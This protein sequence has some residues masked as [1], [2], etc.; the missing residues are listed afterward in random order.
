VSIVT[1]Q[2]AV[3]PSCHPSRRRMDSSALNSHLLRGFLGTRESVL[4]TA[5]RSVQPVCTAHPCAQHTDTQTTLRATSV[6]VGRLSRTAC[7]RSG[8][9]IYRKYDIAVKWPNYTGCWASIS[10]V[11]SCLGGSSGPTQSSSSSSSWTLTSVL[12]VAAA[13]CGCGDDVAC[14]WVGEWRR[15]RRWTSAYTA[16]AVS[17]AVWHHNK[18]SGRRCQIT[19]YM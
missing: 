14:W 9:T 11:V 19:T 6:A 17:A 18:L 1:W 4:Q 2:E 10:C 13:G 12:V 3:W 5:S 7:R 8:L 15:P 16:T